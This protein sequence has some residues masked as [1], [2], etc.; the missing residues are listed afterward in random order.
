MTFW[1]VYGIL[2]VYEP[3]EDLNIYVTETTEVFL[4]T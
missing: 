1:T 3:K 2:Y 4:Q